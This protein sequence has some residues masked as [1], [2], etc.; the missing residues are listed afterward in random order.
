MAKV[1]DS[2]IVGGGFFGLNIANYLRTQLKQKNVLV[3]EKEKAAEKL[4]QET[5]A[6]SHRAEVHALHSQVAE[7]TKR[8]DELGAENKRLK[9]NEI[10]HEQLYTDFDQ[11]MKHMLSYYSRYSPP[12]ASLMQVQIKKYT[13]IHDQLQK[14]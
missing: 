4:E 2:V 12:K 11:G 7:V 6:K 10:I 3:L 9:S 14:I 1:Y 5:S 8:V 13:D